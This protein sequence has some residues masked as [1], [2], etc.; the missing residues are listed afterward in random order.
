LTL[1][2]GLAKK[3]GLTVEVAALRGGEFIGCSHSLT[4]LCLDCTRQPLALLL[5]FSRLAGYFKEAKPDVVLSF[6]HSINC[7]AALAKLLRRF[8]FRLIVSEHSAFGTRMASDARPHRWR[9]A[10]RARLLYRQAEVC[11]CVSRGVADELVEMNVVPTEKVRVIYNPIPKRSVSHESEH[12][13]LGGG[14]RPPVILSVGR[15]LPLKGLDTLLHAFAALVGE[16]SVS[17]RLMILGD[18]CDRGRLEALTRELKIEKDVCFTGYVPEPEAY[19]EKAALLALSSHYEG[20]ATV[21]TEALACGLN[22]VSA[23]CKSGPREILEEGKWGR[24]VPVGDSLALASA[25]KE[26]LSSPMSPEDLKGRAACF[27]VERAVDAYYD[28]LFNL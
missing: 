16:M 22:V 25:M 2:E 18:G 9:R 7:L 13:W 3:E 27:S 5:P 23:D 26:T 20:F 15:L 8:P 14:E 4:L 21:L 12:P 1:A 11:V 19:M 10:A 6:G 24:L 28:L 17:A